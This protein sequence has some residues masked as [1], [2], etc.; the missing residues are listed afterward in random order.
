MGK[1]DVI[2]TRI[3]FCRFFTEIEGLKMNL[4]ICLWHYLNVSELEFK[5]HTYE[6][7]FVLL[8]LNSLGISDF[9]ERGSEKNS[10][11]SKSP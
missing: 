7:I 10:F 1:C 8:F 5:T 3:S 2:L 11:F 6:P 9:M 4:T